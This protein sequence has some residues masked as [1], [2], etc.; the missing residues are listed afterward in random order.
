[1]YPVRYPYVAGSVRGLCRVRRG[2]ARRGRAAIGGARSPLRACVTPVCLSRG[3]VL[4]R[5][6]Q[7]CDGLVD[8]GVTPSLGKIE[9][10]VAA[11]PIPVNVLVRP[12]AGDFLYTAEERAIMRRDVEL[13]KAAGARWPRR[14]PPSLHTAPSRAACACAS[15]GVVIG[16]LTAEGAV[17]EAAV[18]ELVALAR[19]MRCPRCVCCCRPLV[20]VC[21]YCVTQ[22]YLS[23][24]D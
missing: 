23:S 2:R 24:G 9:A 6:R 16:V 17:D 12:R 5:P 22:R 18:A 4:P 15:S 19:P 21:C 8:G 14:V 11:V 1:M 20:M 7:L 10:V 3:C 13:C